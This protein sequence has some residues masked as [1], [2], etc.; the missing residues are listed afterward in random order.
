MTRFWER[1]GLAKHHTKD[2]RS[3]EKTL[4]TFCGSPL[5]I[6]YLHPWS[7]GA[8]ILCSKGP[9]YP[10]CLMCPLRHQNFDSG[11]PGCT[12]FMCRQGGKNHVKVVQA[13]QEAN[14]TIWLYTRGGNKQRAGHK[15][16]QLF[17]VMPHEEPW[18]WTQSCAV[19]TPQCHQG[20][21]M[22]RHRN[23]APGTL[24]TQHPV[25]GTSIPGD[26]MF[27]GS[28]LG[29]L[30]LTANWLQLWALPGTMTTGTRD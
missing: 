10:T 18:E 24:S 22:W 29:H 25:I 5:N 9:L 7:C 8:T 17:L 30:F 4:R 20:H 28:P 15:A 26:R 27:S 3:E 2:R 6:G 21:Q 14:L 1:T 23:Y 16:P 13:S 12:S 11:V 19:V